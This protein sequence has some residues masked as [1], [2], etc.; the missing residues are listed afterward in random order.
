MPLRILQSG[1]AQVL[2]PRAVPR[3]PSEASQGTSRASRGVGAGLV[4]RALGEVGGSLTSEHGRLRAR[5]VHPAASICVR[6]INQPR[7]SQQIS[8]CLQCR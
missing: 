3:A 5:R 4:P 6:E 2:L 8:N 7:G 1:G